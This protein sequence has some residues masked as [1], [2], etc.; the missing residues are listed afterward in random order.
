M[1]DIIPFNITIYL[2]FCLKSCMYTLYSTIVLWFRGVHG[3]VDAWSLPFF[4]GFRRI[5]F[6]PEL[7]NWLKLG[8]GNITDSRNRCNDWMLQQLLGSALRWYKRLRRLTEEAIAGAARLCACVLSMVVSRDL[9]TTAS[10]FSRSRCRWV[11]VARA[12]LPRAV[13]RPDVPLQ[14]QEEAEGRGR[15]VDIVG[16]NNQW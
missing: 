6:V 5:G 9:A 11:W 15:G 13:A 4:F 8:N 1:D 2:P 10:N 14:S 7:W 3:N 12:I 16:F